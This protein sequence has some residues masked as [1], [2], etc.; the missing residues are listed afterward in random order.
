MILTPNLPTDVAT[1]QALVI[2]K[3][4]RIVRLEK[5]VAD[6]KRAL[7][8]SKSEKVAT[9]QY[10]LALEDIEAAIAAIHAEDEL[11]IGTRIKP[12]EPRRTNRGSLPKHLPRVEEIIEPDNIICDCGC[13]RHVIGEDVTERLDIV[14]SQFRVLVTRRPKYA[15]RDCENGIVQAPAKPHLIEGGIPTEATLATIT[16]NKQGDHLPFY[17]QSGIFARQGVHIDRSTLAAWQG[18]VAYEMTPIYERIKDHLKHSKKLFM[19][20]T[21]APV[22]DPG[23][24]RTKTGYFWALARD[25]RPWGGE[26]PPAVAFTYAP[27]RAGKHA[28]EILQGFEGVLQ[29]DG[30]TGYNRVKDRSVGAPVELAYCWAHARR[31]LF[32]LTINNV[33]PIVEEGIK[34]IK[35]FYRIEAQI[36]SMSADDRR[37]IRQE[38]TLP[39]M[40]AFE[41]WLSYQRSQVSTKSPTGAALKYI[42]KYWDGLNLFLTDGRVEIDSNTVER[43]I[44]PIALQRKNALFAGHDAGAQNWA[45]LASILETC[46][47]NKVEPH[48]YLTG[49]LTAIAHGHK[50]KDIDELLPW[51][52]G[53]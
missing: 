22:L 50:Q 30:Y 15:C 3:D 13:E 46:K 2:S 39:K 16:V 31:K 49:V 48:A 4:D 27:S 35:A 53:K 45:M 24:G 12:K 21:P 11:D 34:Q 37:A 1:L 29:V 17:R 6:F 14:P 5:L 52:F 36:K 9:D 26:E 47:L 38:K 23:R 41:H 43:A 42:A 10:E 25:D 20:E 7:F 28:V 51:N 33:A 44:R 40:Q 8:G 19:D 32:E 18:R